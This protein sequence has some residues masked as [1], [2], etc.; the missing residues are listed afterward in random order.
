MTSCLLLVVDYR[1]L[2][3]MESQSIDPLLRHNGPR[4]RFCIR[5]AQFDFEAYQCHMAFD[6]A[7]QFD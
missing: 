6:Y 3:R 1:S 7:V 2:S 5:L 4:M